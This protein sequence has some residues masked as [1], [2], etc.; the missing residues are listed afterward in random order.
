MS[1]E[2]PRTI[3]DL[4][5]S[6]K[7]LI[8]RRSTDPSFNEAVFNGQIQQIDSMIW[9]RVSRSDQNFFRNFFKLCK[10]ELPEGEFNRIEGMAG[11]RQHI[12]QSTG[13]TS[14]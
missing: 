3:S 8:K 4:V 12:H 10:K 5:K 6:K 9:S 13:A 7:D 1:Q 2:K 11:T 14:N